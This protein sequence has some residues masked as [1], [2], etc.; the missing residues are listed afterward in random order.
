MHDCRYLLR[1]VLEIMVVLM[2]VLSYSHPVKYRKLYPYTCSSNNI[3]RKHPD[4][5]DQCILIWS[6]ERLVVLFERNLFYSQGYMIVIVAIGIHIFGWNL[7]RKWLPVII[8]KHLNYERDSFSIARLQPE[9]L[10]V[11]GFLQCRI[12]KSMYWC[13]K[14]MLIV[15]LWHAMI[16]TEV[17][18]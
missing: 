11:N 3:I 7:I 15:I 8:M 18:T 10:V 5:C 14:N 4:N 6:L 16:Y 13:W 9:E 2:C 12:C 1:N 17:N